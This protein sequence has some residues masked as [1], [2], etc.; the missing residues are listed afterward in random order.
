MAETGLE[1]LASRKSNSTLKLGLFENGWCDEMNG[2]RGVDQASV[3]TNLI[4]SSWDEE[5]FFK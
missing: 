5:I 3:V 2:G 4:P 1:N